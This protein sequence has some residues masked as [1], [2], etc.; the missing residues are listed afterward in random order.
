MGR[1]LDYTPSKIQNGQILLSVYNVL[2]DSQ[3]QVFG[4]PKYCPGPA[5]GL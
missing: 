2:T 1:Y 5:P 4:S 3:D